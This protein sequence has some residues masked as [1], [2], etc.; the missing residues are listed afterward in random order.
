MYRSQIVKN[1]NKKFEKKYINAGNE[2][3]INTTE[4]LLLKENELT[5][6]KNP[7]PFMTFLNNKIKQN[8]LHLI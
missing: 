2:G 5:T 4:R 1:N 8:L 7:L 6:L 3:I